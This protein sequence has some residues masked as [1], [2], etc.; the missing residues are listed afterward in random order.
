M[1]DNITV[2]VAKLQKFVEA[3]ISNRHHPVYQAG[4]SKSP[5]LQHYATNVTMIGSVKPEDWFK[6]YPQWTAALNEAMVY[7]E[8]EQA[9]E[10]A[11]Q[12]EEQKLRADVGTLEGTVKALEAKIAALSGKPDAPL[13]DAPNVAA[14]ASVAARDA[15]GMDKPAAADSPDPVPDTVTCPQCGH[16]FTK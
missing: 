14:E 1:P 13:A 10:A 5:I 15:A 4:W 7:C 2:D 9:R 12:T 8:T 3:A 11:A 6:Q 16:K